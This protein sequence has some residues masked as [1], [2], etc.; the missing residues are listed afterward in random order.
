MRK[1]YL[2]LGII[3]VMLAGVAAWMV[4]SPAAS[5]ALRSKKTLTDPAQIAKHVVV[6]SRN[7]YKDDY[8][9][10]HI[11]GYVDNVSKSD[12]TNVKLNIQLLDQDGNRK[13]LVRYAVQDVAAGSRKTYDANAGSLPGPR[14]AKVSVA[15]IEVYR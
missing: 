11:E 2:V 6:F 14:Q 13:E 15:S 8:D 4:L 5:K 10:S 7:P 3:A 12:V 1:P 9:L